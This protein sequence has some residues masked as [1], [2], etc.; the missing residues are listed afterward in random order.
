MKAGVICVVALAVTGGQAGAGFSEGDLIINGFGS[1]SNS[2]IGQYAPDGTLLTIYLGT[3]SHWEGASLT[4]GGRVVTTRRSSVGVNIFDP[5]GSQVFTFNTPEVTFVPGDVNVFS[6]GVLAVNDQEGNVD[7]YTQEG[8]YITTYTG[9]NMVRA[10]GGFVD[11]DD[12]LWIGD[13]RAVG[14]NN[15]AI[16]KFA[17]DG[18][19]LDQFELDW[20][21]GDLVVVEDG[22]IWASDRNNL[23]V[24]HLSATGALIDSFMT[25]VQGEFN[26]IAV[27]LDGTIWAGGQTAH[28][29]FHYSPDGVF[30]DSLPLTHP[31]GSPVFMTVVS[32]T[33]SPT[34]ALDIKPGSCPNSFNFKSEG[35]LPVALVGID[36]IPAD[37]VDISTLLLSRA[38][39]VGGSVAP[40]EGPPGPHTVLA[41]V[42][43]PFDGELCDC[44]EWMG[45]GI[46]DVSMKFLTRDVV[47]ALGLGGMP[48]NSLVELTL[49]GSLLD[50]TPFRANDCIRIVGGPD[51]SR[52]V[53]FGG[54]THGW[55]TPQ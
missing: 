36:E 18:T 14:A 25:A 53:D 49:T 22:T 30:L 39:G 12:N 24:M 9:P 6:D 7:L 4:P 26:T 8:V 37:L 51:R 32:T 34:V 48:A 47:D 10:L 17:R 20:E 55:G 27:D 5:D 50:G 35:K 38:D 44:H 40:I 31:G 45:D 15:G 13:T 41:D 33:P 1:S 52:A 23:T 54:T 46:R 21:P 19:L 16:Y 11:S 29:I 3:G 2:S 43:T 28:E 42:A